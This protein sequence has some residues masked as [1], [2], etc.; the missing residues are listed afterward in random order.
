MQR[1]GCA[2]A[3]PAAG[4]RRHTRASA[5]ELSQE[6]L[7]LMDFSPLEVNFHDLTSKSRFLAF[8]S[9]FR[10]SGKRFPMSGNHSLMSNA[11]FLTSKCY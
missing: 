11:R 4:R 10:I 2:S 1:R 5:E 3:F 9:G 6:C 8:F 7:G